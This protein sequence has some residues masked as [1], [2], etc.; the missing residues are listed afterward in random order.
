V[1]IF[2]GNVT[3]TRT[4]ETTSQDD[5]YNE[6]RHQKILRLRRFFNIETL[7]VP[8]RFYCGN[9]FYFINTF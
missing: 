9:K 7:I 8:F 2:A 5:E 6:Q 3:Q 1:H 4:P